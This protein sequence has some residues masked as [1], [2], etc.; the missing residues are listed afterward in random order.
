MMLLQRVFRGK[1]LRLAAVL[2]PVLCILSACEDRKLGN[3]EKGAMAGGAIGAGLGAIVG[4]QSGQ[5]GAGAAVGAAFGSLSGGLIGSQFD[6]QNEQLDERA[7]RVQEQDEALAENRRLIQELRGTGLE[8][9]ISSRGVV[10]NVPNVLFEFDS[11]RLTSDARRTVGEISRVLKGVKDRHIS[12]EGHTDSVG[13]PEYN[14]SLSQ[15]RAKTVAVAL[16]HDGVARK[17]VSTRG[18]G[19]TRPVESNDTSGGREKNRRVEVVIEN[20]H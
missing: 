13:R 16:V 11:S 6:S 2:L 8:T 9:K 4:N 20:R 1:G 19:E 10:V 15:R 14:M 12:V 5:A 7:R 18:F 17:Q 3:T